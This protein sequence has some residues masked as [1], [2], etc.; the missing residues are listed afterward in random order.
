MPANDDGAMTGTTAKTAAGTPSKAESGTAA[1]KVAGASVPAG[2][3]TASGTTTG[4]AVADTDPDPAAG[5][6]AGRNTGDTVADIHPAAD[7]AAGTAANTATPDPSRIVIDAVRKALGD[8]NAYSLT[9]TID[10]VEVAEL[11]ARLRAL[12]GV[13]VKV[14]DR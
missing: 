8:L 7:A 13:L 4:A 6:A 1:K 12:V 11:V 10:D 9:E 2:T 5:A 14:V 3:G